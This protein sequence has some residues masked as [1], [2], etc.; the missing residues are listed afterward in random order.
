[1]RTLHSIAILFFVAAP[2]FAQVGPDTV[3]IPEPGVIAL[4]GIG[5]LAVLLGRRGKK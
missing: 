2:A 5:A 3:S 4:I 1:M